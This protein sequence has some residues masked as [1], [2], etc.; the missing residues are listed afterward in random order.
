MI[1]NFET[2]FFKQKGSLFNLIDGVAS[3]S[4][5]KDCVVKNLDTELNVGNTEFSQKFNFA[6]SDRIGTGLDIETDKT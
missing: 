1:T 3:A 6:L 2:G 4:C 5:F